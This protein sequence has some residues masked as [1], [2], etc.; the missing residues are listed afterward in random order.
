MIQLYRAKYIYQQICTAHRIEIGTDLIYYCIYSF[1][2]NTTWHIIKHT[3][4]SYS[5][6]VFEA[7]LRFFLCNIMPFINYALIWYIKYKPCLI[8]II[9]Q[10]DS[11][12]FYV[13]W[14]L[15]PPSSLFSTFFFLEIKDSNFACIKK[16]LFH[17]NYPFPELTKRLKRNQIDE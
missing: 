4:I 2:C 8:I 15:F 10:Q 17:I 13:A 9:S 6:L 11:I 5:H 3:F 14:M 16:Y 7:I 1:R 12:N